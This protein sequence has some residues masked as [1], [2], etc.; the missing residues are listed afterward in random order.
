MA[1]VNERLTK[2]QRE[3]FERMSVKIPGELYSL[4]PIWWTID[5]RRKIRL[6]GLGGQR[7]YSNMCLFY[8]S[9]ENDS[10]FLELHWTIQDGTWHW[11][12][13]SGESHYLNNPFSLNNDSEV[14]DVFKEALFVYRIDGTTGD[15]EQS[16]I[17]I[18]F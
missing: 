17:S 12:I 10:I 3:E 5:E 18:D 16:S 4:S 14:Y 6:V 13:P 15:N 1:F 7:D 11:Y 2:E 8:F 9:I